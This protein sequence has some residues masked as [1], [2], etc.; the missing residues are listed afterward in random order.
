M[1]EN[2]YDPFYPD[3]RERY[4]SFDFGP[5]HFISLGT[6]EFLGNSNRQQQLTWL[7]RDLEATTQ[8]WRIVFMHIP[9]Y[10]SS[11][12]SSTPSLRT[13]LQPIFE[14]YGVQVVF[15]GHEHDYARGA[16]WHELPSAYSPV[17]HVVTG[18][19]GAL[20]GTPTP[21]P[22]LVRWASAFHYLSVKVTDCRP[23]GTCELTFD[24]IGLNGQPF[25]HFTLPLRAQQ[26]DA[27]PPAVSWIAPAAGANLSNT[28]AIRAAATDDQGIVKVDV[29]VDGRL[30]FVDDT[31]PYE[32]SWD[33]KAEHNGDRLLELRAVDVAGRITASDTRMVRVSNANATVEVLSPLAGESVFTSMPYRIRWAGSGGASPLTGFR[34]ESSADGKTFSPVPGC[35]S[36]PSTVRECLWNSPGP[37]STKSSLRVTAL[38]A[39][40]GAV[41][42]SPGF[43]VRSGTP[44][45]NLTF[46][47]KTATLALGSTQ[48]VSWTGNTEPSLWRVEM[49]GD[50]GA[51]WSVLADDQRS[52]G[53]GWHWFVT[54]P[55]TNQGLVRI[56][57]L[58]SAL[59]DVNSAFFRIAAPT[60]SATAP[61]ASTV[62]KVN[63]QVAVRWSTNL[64]Q[65]DRVNVRLSTDGGAMFPYVLAGSVEARAGT[66]TVRVPSL[67]TNA[68]RLM[69]ESLLNPEWQA[70]NPANFRIVP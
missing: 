43:R 19:G 68:A 10:G 20:L 60:L 58:T 49:S 3:R 25:D 44:G 29:W 56:S 36:L 6:N 55:V 28:V 46:P 69:I 5:I 12:L 32:W 1:P 52:F 21:G 2:G 37:V 13:T 59:Q 65:Y 54:G 64:G 67:T 63:S 53:S 7:V 41:D 16:P 57:S 17:M 15:A 31:A 11:D 47:D 24:A 45:L 30:R 66:V 4:Y 61:T 35:G 8:P 50:G 48:A 38:D 22:W 62:W 23:S 26:V 40:G 70:V 34:V 9:A 18:G 51:S 39:T 42:T 33:T 27:A 14:R